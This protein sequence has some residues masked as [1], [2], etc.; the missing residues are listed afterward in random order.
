[1]LLENRMQEIKSL[2]NEGS[3]KVFTLY[4][5]VDIRDPEQQGDKWKIKLKHFLDELTE[6]AQQSGNHEEKKEAKLVRDKVEDYMNIKAGEFKRGFVLFTTAKEDAWLSMDVNIPVTSEFAWDNQAQLTQLQKLQNNYPYTG[7]LVLQKDQAQLIETELKE[8][9]HTDYYQL[10]LKE[11]DWRL[12]EGPQ[13][14]DRTTGGIKRDEYDDRVQANQE[15]W[16]K[17]LAQKVQKKAKDK[18]WQAFYLA[19]EKQEVE[20]MRNYFTRNIDKVVPLNL[21]GR[22]PNDIVEEIITD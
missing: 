5:N 7:I 15:R 10:D 9:L 4:L 3:E 8:T 18:D 2:F 16:L 21:L 12:H 13:G 1:M 19:G 20:Q 11:N 14:D 17:N 22:A 6:R